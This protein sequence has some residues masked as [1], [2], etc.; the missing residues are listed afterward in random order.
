MSSPAEIRQLDSYPAAFLGGWYA[1]AHEE[2]LRPGQVLGFDIDGEQLVAFRSAS[3]PDD[4]G[5]LNR[6]CPHLGADLSQ[7]TVKKNCLECPFHNWQFST[8]GHVTKIPYTKSPLRAALKARRWYTTNFHGVFCVY[9][10]QDRARRGEPPPYELRRFPASTPATSCF[11]AAATPGCSPPHRRARREQRRRR[12]LSIP[13]RSHDRALHQHQDPRHHHPPRRLVVPRPGAAASAGFRDI[14]VLEFLGRR[15]KFTTATAEVRFFGPGS[16]SAVRLHLP[17][18]GDMVLFQTHTPTESGDP[19]MHRVRFR[20]FADKKIPRP[21]VSYV[22]GSWMSQLQADIGIW[23]R[24]HYQGKPMLM[25]EERQ[26]LEMRRWYR[27]FY[28]AHPHAHA[29]TP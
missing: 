10:D 13:P 15:L 9:I 28:P 16:V 2:E 3:D 1:F 5:V 20:W 24:K 6:H 17:G 29:A 7:G 22:V 12:P 21:L 4:I 25:P 19:M 8:D 23:G 11:A 14:A 26:L 27:Q 18:P